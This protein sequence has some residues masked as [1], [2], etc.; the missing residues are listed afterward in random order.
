ME[1]RI[2]KPRKGLW[3]YSVEA[4]ETVMIRSCEN[5]KSSWKY[6]REKV[7]VEK[8]SVVDV[9]TKVNIPKVFTHDCQW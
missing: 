7:H 8:P 5:I 3:C 1:V 2:L 9:L 4:V 6:A